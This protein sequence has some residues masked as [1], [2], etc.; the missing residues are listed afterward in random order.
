MRNEYRERLIQVTKDVSNNQNLNFQ[1][2]IRVAN[3]YLYESLKEGKTSQVIFG[4]QD[5]DLETFL[6]R[7]FESISILLL[8][9]KI[10]RPV[11]G[12]SVD[13]ERYEQNKNPNPKLE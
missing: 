4:A 12:L 6:S 11:E 1:D 13:E 8:G 5:N 3:T 9:W 2:I 10:E 7:G